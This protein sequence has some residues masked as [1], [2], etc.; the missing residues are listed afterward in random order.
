MWGAS[1]NKRKMIF[2]KVRKDKEIS[3]TQ[4]NRIRQEIQDHL[5]NGYAEKY[6]RIHKKAMDE[7]G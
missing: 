4:K 5:K 3:Y 7:Y 1:R 6:L 2:I